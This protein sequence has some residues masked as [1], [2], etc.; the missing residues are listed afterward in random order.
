MKCNHSTQC[1]LLESSG[2]LTPADRV[3]LDAHL[4][5]CPSCRSYRSALLH[6]GDEARADEVVPPPTRF[7]VTSLIVEARRRADQ[8]VARRRAWFGLGQRPVFAFAAAAVAAFAIGFGIVLVASRPQGSA[9][10]RLAIPSN[11]WVMDEWVDVRMDL[12]SEDLASV[13]ED[14][15]HGLSFDLPDT[16][17]TLDEI[18]VRILQAEA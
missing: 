14:M 2:E 17:E 10:A 16:G 11:A 13:A 9:V 18:A 5:G 4:A 15:Q 3:R 8:E 1:I 7:T 6:L 12:L